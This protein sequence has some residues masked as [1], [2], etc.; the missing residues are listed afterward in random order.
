MSPD[1]SRHNLRNGDLVDSVL[2]SEN[3]LADSQCEAIT[4]VQNFRGSQLGLVV[5]LSKRIL[6][7]FRSIGRIFKSSSKKHMVG[8]YAAWIIPARAV[9]AYLYAVWNWAKGENVSSSM[10]M[11]RRQDPV[12]ASP[13]STFLSVPL[14][15]PT[16]VGFFHKTPKPVPSCRFIK[17]PL[18]DL[19]AEEVYGSY[20][21]GGTSLDFRPASRTLSKH[22]KTFLSDV[23][24]A[25]S[26]SCRLPTFE[27][28][29]P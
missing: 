12:V 21:L 5:T 4:N 8:I 14:P 1:F 9:V 22:L 7:L 26:S 10:R 24:G 13:M 16:C 25:V 19:G 18:A 15:Q 2:F 29:L 27:K 11:P 17:L 6:V 3:G 28:G 20:K 23:T